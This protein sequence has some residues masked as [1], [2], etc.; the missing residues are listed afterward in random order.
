MAPRGTRRELGD[1]VRLLVG[2]ERRLFAGLA[3]GA[4]G[5]LIWLSGTGVFVDQ[6]V[7]AAVGPVSTSPWSGEAALLAGTLFVLWVLLPA[8][9]AVRLVVGEL[10]NIRGNIEKRY[11][12][13]QPLV[14]LVPPLLALVAVAVVALV[15][16]FGTATLLALGVASV[17]L[18]VR[19]VAY[20]YRVYSLSVPRLLQAALFVAAAVVS[21]AVASRTASLAGQEAL[22]RATAR[23]YGVYDIAFGTI[24]LGAGRVP[25]LPLAGAVVPAVVAFSYVWFQVMA[26]LV[27]RIRR[28]DVPRSAIRAG[29]RYPSV[30]QPGTQRRLAMGTASKE[31]EDDEESARATASADSGGG[32]AGTEDDDEEI[33]QFGQTRV[34]TPPEEESADSGATSVKSEL[35]P[36]CGATYEADSDR[37][38]C[39]NCNAELDRD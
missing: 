17:V 7:G 37:T 14:L 24:P 3:G 30:I 6:F 29:Q 26:G 34:Y 4:A 32:T 13:D 9:L 20:G 33:E 25:L 36:I 19:A 12:V 35:C 18:L 27:V 31:D 2:E 23:Q 15:R 8:I 16:G 10:T 5:Y 28:P 22:V 39:P 38:H 1:S 21:L 11:R